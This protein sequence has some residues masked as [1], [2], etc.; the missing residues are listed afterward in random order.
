MGCAVV[1]PTTYKVRNV[2][3]VESHKAEFLRGWGFKR[4]C[5]QVSVFAEVFPLS[6]IC[7][8]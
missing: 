7:V 8:S 1:K 3:V 4:S 6:C 2:N 5:Y